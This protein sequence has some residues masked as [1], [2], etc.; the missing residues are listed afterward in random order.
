MSE[1]KISQVLRN[2]QNE[3]SDLQATVVVGSD[4]LIIGELLRDSRVD[5]ELVGA[6]MALLMTLVKRAASKLGA[7]AQENLLAT[8]N[9]Y[10]LTILLGDGQFLHG[11]LIS[12][13]GGSL[14]MTRLAMREFAP[15]IEQ[16]IRSL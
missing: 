2:F 13:D 5:M 16:A 8:E 4:G 7:A 12:K 6:Q 14:G 10:L 9:G 11:A 1:N 3:I 15:A